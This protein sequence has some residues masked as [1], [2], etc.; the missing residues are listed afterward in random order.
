MEWYNSLTTPEKVYFYIAMIGTV[1]LVIQIVMMLFSFGG[2]ADAD[3]DTDFG[4]DGDFDSPEGD[5]GISL[6][7][8]KGI[9]SFLAIGGWIGLLILQINPDNIALSVILGVVCGFAAMVLVALAMRG[10]YRL[11]SSGNLDKE[12]C[13]EKKPLCMCLSRL[14][15]RAGEKSLSPRRARIPNWTQSPTRIPASPWTNGW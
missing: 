11:Q 8:L 5:L 14:T 2:G 13:S 12:N 7:T 10:L 6:F 9:T 15:A 3:S 4:G 1:L